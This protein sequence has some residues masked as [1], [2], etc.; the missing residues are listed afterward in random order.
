MLQHSLS[1]CVT[2]G[3]CW[4]SNAFAPLNAAL[5]PKSAVRLPNPVFANDLNDRETDVDDLN[6]LWDSV[7][8]I[9]CTHSE[10]DMTMPWQKERQYSSTASGFVVQIPGL[11][12]R[13]I[14]NAHA[15]EYGSIVQVSSFQR[16]NSFFRGGCCFF[17]F[18]FCNSS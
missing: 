16:E 14:T 10:P 5:R 8:R 12:L 4:C 1:F 18:F 15:V 11:G 3:L 2:A 9:Y 17:F 7:V 6:V 13:I